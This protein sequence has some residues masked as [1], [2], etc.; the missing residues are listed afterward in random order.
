MSTL[1]TKGR[2]GERRIILR[3]N[4]ISSRK[5]ETWPFKPPCIPRVF[6]SC[7]RVKVSKHRVA[8][9]RQREEHKEGDAW[10]SGRDGR[11]FRGCS[12]CAVYVSHR[13][14]AWV[15][16]RSHGTPVGIRGYGVE[17]M[18]TGHPALIRRTCARGE[19]E[20]ASQRER[21]GR[22]RDCRN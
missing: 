17:D 9:A 19:R 8:R 16:A 18:D 10:T 6:G 21:E 14:P 5:G 4:E 11:R 22:E 2:E 20:P 3:E 7:R 13:T 1:Y 12:L 15:L